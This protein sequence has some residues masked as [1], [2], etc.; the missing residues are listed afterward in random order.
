MHIQDIYMYIQD[1][2]MYILLK[3]QLLICNVPIVFRIPGLH[4]S[5]RNM[6]IY[7]VYHIYIPYICN[8]YTMHILPKIFDI[9][10]KIF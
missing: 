8:V 1:I 4:V 5:V 7:Y 10:T 9:Q 2:Y 3:Y 6:M